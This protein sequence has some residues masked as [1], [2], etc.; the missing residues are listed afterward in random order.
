MDSLSSLY[1]LGGA[2]PAT[3]TPDDHAHAHHRTAPSATIGKGPGHSLFANASTSPGPSDFNG[4]D[5][6]LAHHR[7]A[8]AVT[9]GR[10]LGH[11]WRRRDEVASPGPTSYNPNDRLQAHH[12]HFPSATFGRSTG[13]DLQLKPSSSPGLSHSADDKVLAHRRRSSSVTIGRGPGHQTATLNPQTSPGPASYNADDKLLAGHRTFPV[14]SIGQGPG[15]ASLCVRDSAP[16]P[17]SYNLANDGIDSRHKQSRATSLAG[18]GREH[19]SAEELLHFKRADA[20]SD[21]KLDLNE[22]ESLMRG[23]FTDIEKGEVRSIFNVA[24]RN[25]DGRVDFKELFEYT[26]S[27]AP[28]TRRLREKFMMALAAPGQKQSFRELEE[29]MQFR[30]ADVNLDG[31]LDLP[32]VESLLTRCFHDIKRRDVREIFAKADRNHD[33]KLD[34]QEVIDYT[35]S[36]RDP[37]SQRRREMMAT[38]LAMKLPSSDKKGA[39]IRRSS[40]ASAVG[41]LV[42]GR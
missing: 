35:R 11:Q 5:R 40:S 13:H 2:G 30:R 12:R 21:G 23:R 39:G 42:A 33:G 7:S 9:I 32:E 28:A 19:A 25:H 27:T 38:A 1:D 8:S 29:R 15:H 6:V 20:N 18:T 34:F 17:G 31:H 14:S 22:V 16:A 26:H 4:N 3:Y 36:K 24:D 37:A 41:S 10:G